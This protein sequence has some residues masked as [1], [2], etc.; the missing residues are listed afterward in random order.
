M[1]NVYIIAA[2]VDGKMACPTKIGRSDLPFARLSALQTGSPVELA[3]YAYF[4]MPSRD[5]AVTVER[6][7]REN[8]ADRRRHGEWF[9]IAPMAAYSDL[10]REIKGYLR[11]KF[12]DPRAYADM[13]ELAVSEVDWRDARAH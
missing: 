8:N 5:A 9:N 10:I 6:W 11:Q 7:F 3:V 12:P 4:V 1:S 13:L 2:I